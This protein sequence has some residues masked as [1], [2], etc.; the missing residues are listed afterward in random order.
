MGSGLAFRLQATVRADA[1][2]ATSA[3]DFVQ[4][5]NATPYSL[6]QQSFTT[7]GAGRLERIS[8]R[9][10]TVRKLR[11]FGAVRLCVCSP[12]NGSILQT[13]VHKG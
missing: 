13:R 8:A 1:R 12:T 3:S 11:P 9:Q 5:M 7:K 2:F 4:I 10:L 6:L